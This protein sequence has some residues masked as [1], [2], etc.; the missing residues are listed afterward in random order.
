MQK[1]VNQRPSR[2]K[3]IDRDEIKAIDDYD[4]PHQVMIGNDLYR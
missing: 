2:V 3:T 4:T 1:R